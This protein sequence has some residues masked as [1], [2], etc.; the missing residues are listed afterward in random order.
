LR[1]IDAHG[2]LIGT[3]IPRTLAR[4]DVLTPLVRHGLLYPSAPGS[5]NAYRRSVLDRLFPLPDD[6]HDRHGADYFTIYGAAA[7]GSVQAVEEPLARYRVHSAQTYA[8]AGF[9]FG[10][11]DRSPGFLS[12]VESREARLRALI[13]ERTAGVVRP[14]DRFL[15]FS[16]QKIGFAAAAMDRGHPRGSRALKADFVRLLKALWLQRAYSP[17]QRLGL[18]AW[19]V[20]VLAA[21]R[22]FKVPLVRFVCD[23]ASRSVAR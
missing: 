18:T 15:D 17:V 8:E 23:P 1:L 21:P 22:Q 13:I 6:P 20:L 4:G 5:G 14:P 19:A 10:N 2:Q 9:V 16:V 12:R 3:S 11:A 7:Y